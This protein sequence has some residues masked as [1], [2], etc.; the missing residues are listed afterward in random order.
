M[1]KHLHFF[2]VPHEITSEEKYLLLPASAKA[3]Y[4]TLCKLANLYADTDG[5]F[6]RSMRDLARDSGL[7]LQTVVKAKKALIK[8]NYIC[9]RRGQYEATNYRASDC[10]QVNGFVRLQPKK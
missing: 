5:W 8:C 10:Y 1:G 3:L 4:T 9:C 6:Y 2:K 7:H